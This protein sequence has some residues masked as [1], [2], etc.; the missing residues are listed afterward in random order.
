MK[1]IIGQMAKQKTQQEIIDQILPNLKPS[2][3][4]EKF[5]Y[6]NALTKGIA[7]CEKHGEFHIL[8]NKLKIGQ[9]CAKCVPQILAN[10]FK[11]SQEEAQGKCIETHGDLYD[12]SKFKYINNNTNAIFICK[13]HGEYLQAPEKNWGGRHCPKC[14]K[15]S[16]VPWNK[17][18]SLDSIGE[19][20]AVHNNKYLYLDLKGYEDCKQLKEVT[21]P[22]HG[23]F[24]VTMDN[25]IGAKSGCVKCSNKISLAEIEIRTFIEKLGLECEGPIKMPSKKN[26]DIYIPSLKIGIEY[27]GLYFHGEKMGKSPNYHYEKFIEAQ[28]IGINLIQIFED[29]YL[30]KKEI[31]LSC[32]ASKLGFI[33][34]RTFARRLNIKEIPVVE[35]KEFF[36]KTH[37]QGSPGLIV[38]TWGLFSKEGELHAAMSIGSVTNQEDVIEVTRFSSIGSVV[39]GFSKLLKAVIAFA[40]N[41][42]TQEI[43][44]FSDNRWS[45]GNVYEY[46]GFNLEF[47]TPPNYYWCKGIQRFNKRG[48][49]RKYLPQKLKVFDPKMSEAD[50]CRANGYYKIWDAGKRKWSMKV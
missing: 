17:R 44:S 16:L 21:C 22:Y 3:S 19:A 40:K 7:I 37:L 1:D 28:T 29:E 32:L 14:S 13:I 18:S 10:K 6:I 26:I 47:N 45:L 41:A 36:N 9:G 49:Q 23:I 30:L 43:I 46:S 35:A 27:N 20:N 5:V 12:L 2:I 38:K 25:H 39:G 11:L 24:K 8:A 33:T 34:K 48:F 15:E 31:T 4:L 42:G 50:N